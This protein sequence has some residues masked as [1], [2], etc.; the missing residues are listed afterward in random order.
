MPLPEISI[1]KLCSMASESSVSR[2]NSYW[3]PD[4]LYHVFDSGKTCKCA[5][6]IIPHNL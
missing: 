3:E 4:R 2:F 6:V 1:E 5:G